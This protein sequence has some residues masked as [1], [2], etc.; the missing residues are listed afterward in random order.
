MRLLEE[1]G[2]LDQLGKGANL[3]VTGRVACLGTAGPFA[4]VAFCLD[5]DNRLNVGYAV[6]DGA[7]GPWA[8]EG[9]EF[10]PFTLRAHGYYVRYL[11]RF[12]TLE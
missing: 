2:V 10:E 7:H 1:E 8:A 9:G 12:P 3:V 11:K 6:G 4:R 5:D